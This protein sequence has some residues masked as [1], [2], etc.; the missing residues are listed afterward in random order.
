MTLERLF[1]LK[2]LGTELEQ[3][4]D[5]PVR[6]REVELGTIASKFHFPTLVSRVNDLFPGPLDCTEHMISF[7]S[8]RNCLSHT[9][10]IVT[11]RHCNTPG[12]DKL[13]VKGRRSKLFFKRGDLEVP[14]EV[15]KPGPENAA[16]ML[17]AEDFQIEF[18]VGQAIQLSLKQFLDIL[19]TCLFLLMDIN[20]KLGIQA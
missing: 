4:P 5:L 1:V 18:A 15:G 6:V 12:K 9:R 11:E 14:A 3:H 19:H 16:L 8:A 17:G 7:N 2:T 13:V 20:V 10:G